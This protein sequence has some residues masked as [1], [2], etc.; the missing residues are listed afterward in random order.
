[1]ESAY[2]GTLEPGLYRRRK[3]LSSFGKFY[4]NMGYVP[5]SIRIWYVGLFLLTTT[6]C[7][8][9]S[10]QPVIERP[11]NTSNNLNTEG[12]L[13]ILIKRSYEKEKNA[14]MGVG[15]IANDKVLTSS[16]WEHETLINLFEETFLV[17]G[18]LDAT[19]SEGSHPDLIV[20]LADDYRAS[21]EHQGW[22]EASVMTYTIIPCW[23]DLSVHFVEYELYKEKGL[24]R[25]YIYRYA[26]KGAWWIGLLPFVWLNLFTNSE[27]E[28]L[29]STAR[30]FLI[31]AEA[32]GLL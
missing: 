20:T 9:F 24:Q 11:K 7:T 13:S 26:R 22:C 18:V 21:Y 19:L 17:E 1:M 27:E 25:K 10:Y 15:E 12:H 30:Q 5:K 32:D 8:V 23:G 14:V 16:D 28:A 31:E 3:K 29:A 2:A 6:S 4:L